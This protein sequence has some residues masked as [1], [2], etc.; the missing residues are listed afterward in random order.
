MGK[1]A[2]K[3][4]LPLHGA[5]QLIHIHLQLL[6]HGVE[7]RRQRADLIAAAAAGPVAQIPVRQLPDSPGQALQRI[8]QH[9]GH[10]PGQNTAHRHQ[11]QENVLAVDLLS[12]PALI[13]V[14]DVIGDIQPQHIAAG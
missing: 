4:L 13:Q 10:R 14:A 11:H 6:R 2:H 7:V 1:G 9:V 12:F 3:A 5:L 8:G